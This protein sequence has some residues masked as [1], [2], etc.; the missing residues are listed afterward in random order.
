M[1]KLNQ[2]ELSLIYHALAWTAGLCLGVAAASVGQELI[3]HYGDI[4]NYIHGF[5]S[6]PDLISDLQNLMM[7]GAACAISLICFIVLH[8]AHAWR[9]LLIGRIAM[10]LMGFSMGIFFRIAGGIAALQF[11][12]SAMRQ[13]GELVLGCA[14]SA[15]ELE[16][17]IAA[18]LLAFVCTFF[19]D[20]DLK[21]RR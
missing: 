16:V 8:R 12:M 5:T 19:T 20:K 11:E 7:I 3:W 14:Y 2:K 17:C 13:N 18:L 10:L 1:K 4:I 15:K 9:S 21:R 6:M